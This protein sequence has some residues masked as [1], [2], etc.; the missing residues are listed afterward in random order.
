MKKLKNMNYDRFRLAVTVQAIGIALIPLIFTWSITKEYTL[1]TSVSL[2]FIW[3]CQVSYLMYYVRKT[4]RDLA[5]FL[6]SL[7]HKDLTRK[8]KEKG[9]EK[10][11]KE[12][13]KVFNQISKTISQAKIEKESE[14]FYF[15]HTIK[16]VGIGLIS[17][18][19]KGKVEIY[20]EAAS[21]LFNKKHIRNIQDLDNVKQGLSDYL[22]N[23]KHNQTDLIKLQ[24]KN[25]S[26]HLSVK[27]V[28]FIIERRRIKLVSLQN[29]RS[30]IEQGEVD[31]WQ[32]LIKVLNHEIINS[33]SP[34]NLLSSTLIN[35]FEQN[36]KPKPGSTIDDET[37]YN[38]IAGLKAIEKR[39]KGL[40]R[41]IES[42]G[43]L[44]K[45]PKPKYSTFP[46]PKLFQNISALLKDELTKKKIII[47]F[48]V[49]PENLHLTADEKL[50]EQ[51]LINLIQNSVKALEKTPEPKIN[52][53]ALIQDDRH[54]IEVADNGDGIPEEILEDIFVPFF[55]T[56]KNGTGIG[57]S[58]SRQ[59]MQLHKGTITARSQPGVETIFTLTF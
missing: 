23:L 41:F 1:V 15:L 40:K 58:I 57:L 18:D 53:S 35:Y 36:G 45:V 46:I 17:F 3:I 38:S 4:N 11:F 52:L 51:V 25:E 56:R 55:S 16:H 32:R 59:I 12:L 29:I 10:T 14:H 8:Y 33:L 6:H 42:Y 54:K 5:G 49:R 37:I 30:E 44:T 50:V 24:V 20:N 34:I 39:S 19:E 28:E 31:A 7:K 22:S 27:A 43:S 2:V 13:Y 21:Q 48:R 26:I 9:G 47:T